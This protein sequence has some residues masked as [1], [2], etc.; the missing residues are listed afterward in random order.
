MQPAFAFPLPVLVRK[1]VIGAYFWCLALDA[2]TPDDRENPDGS[3]G[4]Q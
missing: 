3:D 2:L 1:L 4:W